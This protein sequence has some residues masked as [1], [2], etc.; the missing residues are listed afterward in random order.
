MAMKPTSGVNAGSRLV[1]AMLHYIFLDLERGSPGESP[2]L[3][4]LMQMGTLLLEQ[5]C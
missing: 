5:I 4:S 2:V 3:G 1:H